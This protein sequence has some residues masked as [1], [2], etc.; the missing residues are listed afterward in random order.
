[1]RQI[2]FR[3]TPCLLALLLAFAGPPAARAVNVPQWSVY[4]TSLTS[5]G[6]STTKNAYTT[7]TVTATFTDPSLVQHTVQGF[8][9]SSDNPAGSGH[10]TYK[11]RYNMNIQGS[12][13]YTVAASN[14]DAGLTVSTPVSA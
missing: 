2:P 6:T 4:E 1:M 7:I 3:T 9:Y 14:G 12:W 11:I 10:V 8:L 13:T 5:V